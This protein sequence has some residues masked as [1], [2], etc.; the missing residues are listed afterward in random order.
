MSG[1]IPKFSGG[2]CAA[3]CVCCH[4][5]IGSIVNTGAMNVKNPPSRVVASY[6][7]CDACRKKLDAGAVLLIEGSELNPGE[8][9]CM[10][11]EDYFKK[12]FPSVEMSS[13]R[14]MFIT[15]QCLDAVEKQFHDAGV[16]IW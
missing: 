2:A 4:K 12:A 9:V 16:R 13:D 3:I 7:P 1:V 15:T 14:V 11:T 6:E 5:P 8:R 10:V